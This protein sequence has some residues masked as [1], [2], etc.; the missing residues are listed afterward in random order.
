MAQTGQDMA[1]AAGD[2]HGGHQQAEQDSANDDSGA[3][4]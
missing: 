2:E 4:H 3:Q 1:M